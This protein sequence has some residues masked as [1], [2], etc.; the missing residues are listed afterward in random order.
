ME[1]GV[2]KTNASPQMSHLGQVLIRSISATHWKTRV[3]FKTKACFSKTL[4]IPTQL[5]T[6]RPC[7]YWHKFQRAN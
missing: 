6:W 4:D 1:G 7:D 2:L 5:T 3:R